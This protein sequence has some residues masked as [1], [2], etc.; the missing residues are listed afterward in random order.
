MTGSSVILVVGRRL[1]WAIPVSVVMS[2][3]LFFSIAGL[4]GNPAAM[5]LGRDATPEAIAEVERQFGFDRPLVDQ[6]LTWMTNALQGDFGRSFATRESV[7]TMIAT[8]LPV[9]LEL[10][11][12]AIVLS[13]VVAVVVNSLTVGRW[14]VRPVAT[15]F[16]IAGIALPNF[17]IGLALIFIFSVSLNWL[18]SVGWVPWSSGAL[19]HLTHIILPVV[20]LSGYYYGAF[21]L[22]YRAEYDSLSQ[23][24][25]VQ[26]ARAKGL[27]ETSVSFRHLLPNSVLPVITYIGLSLGQLVGGAVVVESLFSVPGIGSLLV[28]SVL[29]RDF[30]VML[31]LGMIV[32]VSVVTMNA[33]ADAAYAV[34][35]PQIRMG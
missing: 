12:A 5:M 24:A 28:G 8:R 1:F 3:L 2:I 19:T 35:N 18:P 11:L 9:T 20:T 26:V 22:V 10:G 30:P 15:V 33:L 27:T 29:A 32:V 34:A 13:T 21:S 14:V 17:V 31:A 7:A 6:Y 25:F 23:R 16:A 4:L